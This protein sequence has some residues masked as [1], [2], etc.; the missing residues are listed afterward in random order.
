MIDVTHINKSPSGPS[1]IFK[2][3]ETKK[4]ENHWSEIK[5]AWGAYDSDWI[6]VNSRETKVLSKCESGREHE[7]AGPEHPSQSR[8][9]VWAGMRERGSL[10]DGSVLTDR[11]VGTCPIL[12]FCTNRY[13]CYLQ[14]FPVINIH[15]RVALCPAPA[16]I[17]LEGL[18]ASGRLGRMKCTSLA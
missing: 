13:S 9:M 10:L 5:E 15:A 2:S 7:L 4:S 12:H 11:A 16:G 8:D 3:P 18:P 1:G 17:T 14:C 6:R